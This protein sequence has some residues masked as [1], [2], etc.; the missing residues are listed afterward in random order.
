MKIG[1]IC[2]EFPPG[3]CGGIGVFTSELAENLVKNNCHVVVIGIY[4]DLEN[5]QCTTE[6]NGLLTVYKLASDKGKFATYRNRIRIFHLVKK[7]ADQG[8]IQLIELPDF[9]G[10]AAGWPKLKI[11]VI[12]RL[13]GSL[14][15]FA[16]EMSEKVSVITRLLE[17]LSLNRANTI[18]SVSEYTANKTKRLFSIKKNISVIYN[19]VI[20]PHE[21]RCKKNYE[22][23][24]TITYS[25][26]LVKKKGVFSLAEA[27]PLVKKQYPQ[28]KLIMI[29]KDVLYQGESAQ[30][31]IKRL[32]GD[33]TDSI[34]FTGHLSKTE[35]EN[36]LANSD[37]AIY[38]SYSEA[39]ALAP[40]EAMALGVPT[41]YSSC[42]SGPELIADKEGYLCDPNNIHDISQ[43]ICQLL[44]N[45]KLRKQLGAD[46]RK[47]VLQNFSNTDIFNKNIELYKKLINE[48]EN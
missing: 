47:R 34:S 1:F 12:V 26:S 21:S 27:W 40:M 43:K 8:D 2:N 33:N 44:V 22:P 15:Y 5:D 30:K 35:M 38:P 4:G 13:H 39:F 32:A 14:T 29:G 19:T 17:K 28:A 10:W 37:L 24:Y 11:P 7:L 46:G 48:Q 23:T 20:L 3:K 9:E 42:A 31:I 6:H 45:E 36:M 16:A 41:I 25:G 18:V